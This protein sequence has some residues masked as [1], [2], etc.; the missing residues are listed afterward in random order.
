MN[1]KERLML[2]SMI[3]ILLGP[4]LAAMGV[5]PDD[6]LQIACLISTGI[7]VAYH[8]MAPYVQRIFDHYFPPAA[9][10]STRG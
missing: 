8:T 4:R 6:Q 7:P 10:G 1:N 5:K 2:T 3:G 9:S